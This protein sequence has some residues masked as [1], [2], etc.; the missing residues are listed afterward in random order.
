MVFA[1]IGGIGLGIM[2]YYI[3]LM[4]NRNGVC[5]RGK[6]LFLASICLGTLTGVAIYICGCGYDLYCRVMTGLTLLILGFESVSDYLSLQTCT[7]PI[8]VSCGIIGVLRLV[9]AWIRLHDGWFIAIIIVAMLL[10]AGLCYTMS[11]INRH[12]IGA[13]DFDIF[14]L[15]SFTQPILALILLFSGI[16]TYLGKAVKPPKVLDNNSPLSRAATARVPLVPF[17][18]FMYIFSALCIG[19]V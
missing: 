14:F 5:R 15:I 2:Y 3:V 17:L 9:S 10:Y 12:N 7:I 16:I 1:L 11:I 6:K 19:G 13:G 8:Y 4:L 18:M